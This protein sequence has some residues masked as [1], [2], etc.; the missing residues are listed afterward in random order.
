MAIDDF[1]SQLCL[2]G[3]SLSTSDYRQLQEQQQ[4]Y[5]NQQQQAL[6]ND[7]YNYPFATG[8]SLIGPT[9]GT[10]ITANTL[11]ANQVYYSQP[12][13]VPVPKKPSQATPR[14]W[15]DARVNEVATKGRKSL[16]WST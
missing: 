8:G 12:F 15:L 11:S 7:L 13:D 5:I 3:L 6:Y 14:S 2:G 9:S 10:A 1:K 4:Q 16:D